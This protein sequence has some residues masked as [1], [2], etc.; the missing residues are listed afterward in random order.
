MAHHHHQPHHPQQHQ[1]D[2]SYGVRGSQ[3]R[4]RHPGRPRPRPRCRP[5]SG[6]RPLKSFLSL[7]S[8]A[9]LA[10]DSDSDANFL[11]SS[12]PSLGSSLGSSPAASIMVATSSSTNAAASTAPNNG[13]STDRALA[14]TTTKPIVDATSDISSGSSHSSLLCRPPRRRRPPHRPGRE[15]V[16]HTTRHL[17]CLRNLLASDGQD[18]AQDGV[19]QHRPHRAL[20][21]SLWLEDQRPLASLD[22]PARSWSRRKSPSPVATKYLRASFDAPSLSIDSLSSSM[23]MTTADFEALPPTIQRKVGP[24]RRGVFP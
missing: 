14:S 20:D 13:A 12:S 18:L 10:Q 24:V 1:Q 21:R 7:E 2:R 4:R 9:S 6:R 17:R 23:V 3:C 15:N 5:S 11:L 19:A 22:H 8:R 16:L